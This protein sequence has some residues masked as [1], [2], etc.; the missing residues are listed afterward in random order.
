MK[1]LFPI[2]KPRFESPSQ[3]DVK[4]PGFYQITWESS[5]LRI[6]ILPVKN[7]YGKLIFPNGIHSGIYW[8][9][10]IDF[11]LK[12][13]GKILDIGGGVVYDQYDK[14]FEDYVEYY[15]NFREKGGVYKV[16]GKL[17]INSLYGK[18]G[19]GIKDSKYIILYDE[20]QINSLHLKHNIKS[21]VKLNNITIVEIE[22]KSKIQGI[23]VGLAAAITSKARILLAE[24][25]IHLEEN[26]GRI[27]YCDTDSVFVEFKEKVDYSRFAWDKQ[28]SIYDQAV[29]ALPKTYALKKG[30]DEIVKIK[31][32]PRNSVK[33]DVFKEKFINQ[34][35][36]DFKENMVVNKKD[37]VIRKGNVFK[38]I[39]LSNY[40]KRT[41]TL[42]KSNTIAN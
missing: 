32:I 1:T 35:F 42:D 16:L 3:I 20:K 23:N 29:F 4:N 36:L 33:F 9:E 6:P 12:S 15:N 10:E 7:E 40:D 22:D 30:D 14:L 2:S 24:T 13:G 25:I 21:T 26:G 8:F 17:I 27:L 37:F 34:E 19:S 31:G 11:F 39:D 41:F 18:L 5:N 38:Q 28:D